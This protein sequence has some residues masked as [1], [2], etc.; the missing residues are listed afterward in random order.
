MRTCVFW[1]FEIFLQ[2]NPFWKSY[3]IRVIVISY[4]FWQKLWRKVWKKLERGRF[5]TSCE[6]YKQKEETE[7]NCNRNK[8]S[9]RQSYYP[10]YFFLLLNQDLF[11]EC[12]IFRVGRPKGGQDNSSAQKYGRKFV[13]QKWS[14][15]ILSP[16]YFFE[17][18]FEL[19]VRDSDSSLLQQ[20]LRP[21]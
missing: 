15:F 9:I 3:K 11:D 5:F 10:I 16:L 4:V 17:S 7:K 20:G 6:K 18:Y 14:V 2:E 21:S 12:Q 8:S 1:C 13:C 19:C